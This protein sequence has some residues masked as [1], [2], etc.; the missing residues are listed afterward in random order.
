VLCLSCIVSD[1][2]LCFVVLCC[3]C[4]PAGCAVFELYRV[5][6]AFVFSRSKAPAEQ[7]RTKYVASVIPNTSPL[8]CIEV[9]GRMVEDHTFGPTSREDP[10][11][12]RGAYQ[13]ALKNLY[14]KT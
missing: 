3:C 5:L 6:C 2:R 11:K 8:M 1:V 12:K 14:Q 4:L 10:V 9:T 13:V 7:M